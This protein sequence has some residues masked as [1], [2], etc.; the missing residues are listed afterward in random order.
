MFHSHIFDLFPREYSVHI[1][2]SGEMFSYNG[3][4]KPQFDAVGYKFQLIFC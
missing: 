2:F 3:I 4:I 1:N